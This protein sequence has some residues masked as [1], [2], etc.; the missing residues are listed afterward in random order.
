MNGGRKKSGAQSFVRRLAC[1]NS[2]FH[3]YFDDIDS[4]DGRVVRNYLVVAPKTYA[5]N[6]I[7][8]VAVLPILDAR[9]GL[10]RIFRH[11]IDDYSWEIPR[12]FI[13]PGEDDK[14]SAL[15]E[16]EEETGLLCG[17][18]D[19]VALGCVTPE[20]GILAARLSCY[21]AVHCTVARA[22][23][24]NE[25]GHRDFQLFDPRVVGKMIRSGLIQDPCTL[26]SCFRYF[27]S[28]NNDGMLGSD[29]TARP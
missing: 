19:L 26:F 9:V 20:A 23:V 4:P 18:Q 1:E 3:V 13:E 22:F 15:R 25:L 2:K 6:L 24:P 16:L 8:G 21:A 27:G 10:L 14:T 28:M 12:G 17:Q 7:T 5:G 29:F 11:P